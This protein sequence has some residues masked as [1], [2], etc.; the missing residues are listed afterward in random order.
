MPTIGRNTFFNLIA[1]G[2][3]LLSGITTSILITRG[4]GPT[5][6]GTYSL[7]AWLF[8]PFNLV[9]E[10]GV[11]T[12]T[13][14]FIAELEGRQKHAIGN[15]LFF[16]LFIL[17][18]LAGIFF[19]VLL[20]LFS[21]PLAALFGHPEIQP[22]FRLVGYWMPL[23]ICAG[24]LRARLAGL[25][26][27]DLASIVSILSSCFNVLGT[28]W[29]LVAGSGVQSL[30]W[31]IAANGLVQV[32][33]FAGMVWNQNNWKHLEWV[34][35]SLVQ[36]I[37]RFYGGIFLTIPFDAV[38]WLRSETFFLSRYSPASQMGYYSLASM[39]ATVLVT[40][41]PS[42]LSGVLMPALSSQFGSRQPEAMQQVYRRA[43][44][45]IAWVCIPTGL[46]MAA[47][48]NLAIKLSYGESYSP[49]IPVLQILLIA[50][51]ITALSGPGSAHFLALGKPFY[52]IFWQAPIAALD[53]WLSYQLVPGYGAIGAA[54]AN[55]TGQILGVLSG[56]VYLVIFARLR[57]PVKEL[58]KIFASAVVVS[59]IAYI[60]TLLIPNWFGLGVG[61]LFALALYLP[62]L[63]IF[64]AISADDWMAIVPFTDR[65]PGSLGVTLKRLVISLR[66]AYIRSARLENRKKGWIG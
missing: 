66:A 8:T 62:T 44:K 24:G 53:L 48:A 16:F 10:R 36:R 39:I 38:I 49:V 64:H 30:A 18:T 20:V 21:F 12:T 27:Y 14:K 37:L 52:A 60:T 34:P 26:R 51:V 17:Q 54:T 1:L 23:A 65:C 59:L 9:I 61:I 11:F 63:M 42:A 35:W 47:I 25:Q 6:Y 40:T 55:A 43:T 58:A 32:V 28:L 31:L 33:L 5:Q 46:G 57:V 15:A 2:F 29:I 45:Y 41:L 3:N 56:T 7:I 22:Y 4:L 50:N 13:A 19:G